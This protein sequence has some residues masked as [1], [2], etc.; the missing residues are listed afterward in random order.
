MLIDNLLDFGEVDLGD[1]LSTASTGKLVGTALDYGTGYSNNYW[2][3]DQKLGIVFTVT[4]NFAPTTSWLRISVQTGTAVTSGDLSA[5][6]KRMADFSVSSGSLA[7]V[8]AQKILRLP[9]P[10]MGDEGKR[11]W[12]LWAGNGTALTA[13]KVHAVI[14]PWRVGW[15]A[16][17]Q[18]PLRFVN[19]STERA[20]YVQA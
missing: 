5:G 7:G 14:V 9:F 15:K 4:E 20:E 6:A 10:L 19:T 17:P 18:T 12:Q 11:Y 2:Q 13:G 16:F 8:N 1:E 3:Q